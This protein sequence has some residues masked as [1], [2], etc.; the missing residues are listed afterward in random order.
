MW[1]SRCNAYLCVPSTEQ[2]VVVLS[3]SLSLPVR[4]HAASPH[5]WNSGLSPSSVGV[6]VG[7]GGGGGGAD[8]DGI[9]GG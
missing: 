9:V 3:F 6:D 2:C 8:D 7:G 5:Q 1:D 4:H